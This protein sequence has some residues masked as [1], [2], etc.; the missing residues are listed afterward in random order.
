[1]QLTALDGRAYAKFMVAGAYFLRKYRAE[2]DELNVFPVPDGDTGSNMYLTLRAAALEAGKARRRG[3]A[4]V[5]AASAVGSLTAARGNSGVIMSQLLRGFAY[6]VRERTEIDT[7]VLAA[8]MGG[9]AAMARAAL[10]RP[11]EGTIISVAEAAA[12]A[13]Q[14]AAASE[15]DFYRL[16]TTVLRTAAVALEKTPD[17]LPVL[18]QAEVVDAGAAGLLYF[19]EGILRF[20]PGGAV[21][22]TA[23]PQHA[24]SQAFFTA[25]RAVGKNKYCT[26][27]MVEGSTCEP[28]TLSDALATFGDSLIVGGASPTLKVHIH[29]DRPAVAVTAARCHGSVERLKV[30]DMEVQRQARLADRPAPALSVV[31]VAQGSGFERILRELGAEITIPASGDLSVRDLLAAVNHALSKRVFLLLNDPNLVLA[32]QE[33]RA[34]SR[35]S[36]E[37]VPTGDSVEGIAALLALASQKDPTPSALANAGKR[38][39]SA[40]VFF[41]GK[42]TRLGGTAVEIGKPAAHYAGRQFV[43]SSIAEVTRTVLTAMAPSSGGLISLYYG[44]TQE[45]S[46][47]KAL[48]EEIR[49]AFT[50]AAVEHY[51]GG[52][53]NAE[54]LVSV[55]E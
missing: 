42:D 50:G 52:Q 43:G 9:A 44:A 28:S 40:A 19:L 55:D 49:V 10:Q 11:L 8:A 6:Q 13:A 51:Y 26:E 7:P 45:E 35:K 16:M 23:F 38:V 31:A 22:R 36:V 5:A 54:Y 17:Q 15:P 34:L 12:Q 4:E 39:K 25:E 30:D 27:F 41:A 46:D 14:A 29:T 53:T 2:L 47:A 18:K 24:P 32:A 20:I 48:S 37:I 21:R 3:L 33:V 1:M